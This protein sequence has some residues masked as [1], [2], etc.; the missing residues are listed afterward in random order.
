M[1]FTNEQLVA[2]ETLFGSLKGAKTLDAFACWF[3]AGFGSA[4]TIIIVNLNL[5]KI[6]N[7][8]IPIIIFL[9]ATC[10]CIIQKYLSVIITCGFESNEEAK[11]RILSIA[12]KNEKILIDFDLGKYF[13]EIEKPCWFISKRIIKYFFKKISNGDLTAVARFLIYCFQIQCFLVFGQAI[14]LIISAWGI[15]QRL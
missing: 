8:K 5:V 6:S 4:I 14:L 11:K 13:K 10:A 7:V 3:L 1:N 15:L 9:I 12:E 2:Q